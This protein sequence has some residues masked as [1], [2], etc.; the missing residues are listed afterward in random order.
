MPS[1]P[2]HAA[3][4]DAEKP[5]KKKFLDLSLSQVIGGSLAAA[6]AAALGSRLGV[7]GTVIGTALISVISATG[8]AFYTASLRHGRQTMQTVV[9]AARGRRGVQSTQT[10]TMQS[11]DPAT[12]D[13]SSASTDDERGAGAIAKANKKP[14]L[15]GALAFFLIAILGVTGFELITGSAISG[16]GGT[17]I[18]RVV[19]V[20]HSSTPAPPSNQD[21]QSPSTQ[22]STQPSGST[23]SQSRSSATAPPSSSAQSSGSAS[24]SPNKPS[25]AAPSNSAAPTSDA[26]PPGGATPTGGAVPTVGNYPEAGAS[27]TDAVAPPN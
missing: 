3:V 19:G 5:S 1:D 18:G 25:S 15:I 11:A 23:Q 27:P 21:R 24:T 4:A 8:A 7:A 22:P 20:D 9:I 26:P 10:V 13:S 12:D 14:I 17:T 2:D 6:T 16:G